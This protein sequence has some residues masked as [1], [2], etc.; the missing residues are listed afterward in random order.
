MDYDLIGTK[1][2]RKSKQTEILMQFR[3]DGDE[4][5]IT[6][7]L[8]NIERGG[9]DVLVFLAEEGV[10]RKFYIRVLCDRWGNPVE[11]GDIVEWT[12]DKGNKDEF[13]QKMNARVMREMA[14]RGEGDRF[15]ER[16]LAVVKNGC[17][18]V[19]R[20]AAVQLLNLHGVAE[21]G[22]PLS[23]LRE[24]GSADKIMP[25]GK[26]GRVHNWRYQEISVDEYAELE[27]AAE[28]NPHRQ[29]KE[30]DKAAKAGAGAKSTPGPL[31]T[32]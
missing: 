22:A 26:T 25:D 9:S 8:L 1:V 5:S 14:R 15:F 16:Y 27:K 30:T 4:V 31:T 28:E 18:H 12:V 2:S 13:K 6:D 20:K 17:I 11:D 19:D 7:A 29:N 32:R 23:R 3:K 24:V 21:A 10:Q